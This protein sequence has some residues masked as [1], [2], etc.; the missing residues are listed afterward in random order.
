[1]STDS[2]TA[3]AS[4]SPAYFIFDT[5]SIPDGQL[6]GRVKY[7]DQGLLPA[8]AIARAQTQAREKSRDQSDFLPVSFQFPIAVAVARVD[9]SFRLLNVTSLDSP[10]FRT[11]EI[12]G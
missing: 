8:E 4:D 11:R 3:P 5:E 6:L 12:V 10:E 9:Q 7:P 2:E 1:M